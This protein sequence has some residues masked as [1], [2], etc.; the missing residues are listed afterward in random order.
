MNNAIKFV[1]G[2]FAAVLCNYASAI[3]TWT[4]LDSPAGVTMSA[5]SNTGG[6]NNLANALNNGASQTNYVSGTGNHSGEPAM[7]VERT[8]GAWFL[9]ARVEVASSSGSGVVVTFGDSITDGARS[10]LDMNSRW[11][12]YLARR[13]AARGADLRRGVV[14]VGR[15][16]TGVTVPDPGAAGV[17]E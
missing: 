9:L 7:T 13:L 15:K 4:L 2:A 6:T 12:D 11:P 10:T 16:E 3:T 1:S 14:S 17:G 8:A 5:Y